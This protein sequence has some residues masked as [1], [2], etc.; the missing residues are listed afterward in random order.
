[1]KTAD[2]LSPPHMHDDSSVGGMMLRV[3]VALVPGLF[4]YIWFFGW[5]ILIQ[6]LIVVAFALIIEWLMLRLTRK[7]VSLHLK[8]GSVFVTALLFAITISPF[9]PWWISF[10]GI[11]FAVVFAKHLYGGLGY[12]LFNPAMAGY[13]F[14]LLCFPTHMNI[15]PG[16]SGTTEITPALSDYIS[17]IFTDNP[18]DALSGASPLNH[19][20]SQLNS[21]AM[22]SEI[23]TNPIYGT[24]AGKGWDLIN[25]AFLTGGLW[26]LLNRVIKWHIPAGVLTGLFLGSLVFYIQD[27]ETHIS[28]IFHLFT[29]GTMLCAFFIATDPIT[30]PTTALGRIIFGVLIGALAFIIRTWGGYPEGFAFAVLIAN[31]FAP[32]ISH[33]TNPRVLGEERRS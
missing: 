5:G 14:V 22:V 28:P 12:N 29:G 11:L 8:D 9:T 13:V 2:Y 15:W 4:C 10:I 17:I 33:Y 21:M 1:M 31:M 20:K 23:I 16:V 7:P 19:M 30:A 27:T 24:V 25:L 18:V 6:C 3:C 32:V 26:L